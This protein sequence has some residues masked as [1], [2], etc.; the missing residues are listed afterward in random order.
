M[1]RGCSKLKP[2]DASHLAAA[3]IACV[4]EMHTFDDKLLALDGMIDK[5][6]GT[7]LRICKP[8]MGGPPLPLL[9]RMDGEED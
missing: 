6:D 4:E 2:A 7:K 1:Q 8:A 5:P 3:A 9:E